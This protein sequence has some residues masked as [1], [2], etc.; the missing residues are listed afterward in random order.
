MK[1]MNEI[2]ICI[3]TYNRNKSLINCLKS[4]RNLKNISFFKI[5][6]LIL[7]NSITNNSYKIIK[8]FNKKQLYK[9]YQDHEKKRGIVFARN[10]CLQIAR[11]LKPDYIAF[12]DDDCIVNKN[13]LKNIFTLFNKTDADVITG[14]QLYEGQSKSNH[15]F[16]FEKNYRKKLLKVTWAASNNVFFKFDILKQ[17]KNI[18]FDKNLNKFGMGEDQLFFSIISKIGYKIYWSQN[19]VVTEKMHPHRS[20]INWIK[21]RSKRLGILGHY[22]DIKIHGKI[23]GYLINY[24][25]FLYLF[26][27]S[28]LIYV[29]IFNINRNLDF[30]NN[31]FRCYGKLI[32]PFKFKKIQF[33]QKKIC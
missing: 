1:I 29:N 5:K 3:P 13:W 22:L 14:P 15:M 28:I 10:K 21:E 33:L 16:L 11:K 31:M 32:G 24:I 26:F 20:K 12:I 27:F 7:D 19:V 23:I 6:V 17:V 18:K 2:L 9:I 30:T 4:I 25:K 8:K